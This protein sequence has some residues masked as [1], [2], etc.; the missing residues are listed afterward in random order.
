CEDLLR[1]EQKKCI[2]ENI[3][4]HVNRNFNTD[5]ANKLGLAGRQRINVIFKINEE[6]NVI[7]IRSRAAHPDLEAEAIRVIKTLPKMIPGEHNGKNV[8]VPYSLPI[9]F[10]VQDQSV[11]DET[12]IVAYGENKDKNT[13]E[14]DIEVPFAVIENVPV[15]PGCE[16]LVTNAEKKACMSEKLSKFVIENF[17]TKKASEYGLQGRQRIN[18]IF[19]IDKKGNIIGVR[20]RGPHPALEAEAIR[21]I[22]SL[23]KMKPGMQKGKTVAVPYSLPIIFEVADTQLLDEVAV[24]GYADDTLGGTTL[25]FATVDKAPILP[26]CKSLATEKEKRECTSTGI[27]KFINRNFNTD[28]AESLGLKGRQLINVVFKITKKGKIEIEKSRAPHPDL[29]AEA[30]RVIKSIPKLIPGKH[31]GKKVDVLYSLPIIFQVQD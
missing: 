8:T 9:I 29:G 15:Y 1:E 28:L 13:S 7:G 2:S 24:V 4:K 21:V 6:G 30:M 11:V 17:N 5:L 25:P 26:E 12:V 23:P 14:K 19:K 16:D 18:V 10:Q 22:S 31:K 27:Q 20:S 3:A